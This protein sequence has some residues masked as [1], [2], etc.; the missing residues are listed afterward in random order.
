M[1]NDLDGY[2]FYVH[3]LGRFD[4]VFIVKSLVLNDRFEVTP[5]WK[6]NTIVSLTIKYGDS[7]IILLDYLQLIPESLKNILKSF[8]C[9]VQKG[10]FPYSFVNKENLFYVGDKPSIKYF[11]SISELEYSNIPSNNWELRKETIK[12]LKSDVIGLLEAITKFSGII[13]NKYQLNITRFKT[14]PGLSLAAYRSSYLPENLNKKLK[15]IKGGLETEI[16]K[17]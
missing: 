12:Y 10:Q 14:L 9:N 16:R 5:I 2:T 13:Y 8:N 7:K 11:N 6:D 1:L 3:N 17:A 4:S 15:M